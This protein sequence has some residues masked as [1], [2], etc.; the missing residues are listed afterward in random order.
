MLDDWIAYKDVTEMDFSA[1]FWF[2]FERLF[3]NA[4]FH[5]PGPN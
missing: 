1:A 3:L 2:L 5:Y 4:D